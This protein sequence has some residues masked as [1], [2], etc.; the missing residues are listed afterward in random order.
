MSLIALNVSF[1]ANLIAFFVR[2]SLFAVEL[3]SLS[4]SNGIGTG[5][6]AAAKL[7]NYTCKI[8]SCKSTATC[9]DRSR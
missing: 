9:Q 7:A 5:L 1:H 4:S 6:F 2:L 3:D 8:E